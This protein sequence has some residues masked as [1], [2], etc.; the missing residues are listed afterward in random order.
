MGLCT[1]KGAFCGAEVLSQ[2]SV[3][4]NKWE[5]ALSAFGFLRSLTGIKPVSSLEFHLAHHAWRG[6]DAHEM[7]QREWGFMTW[8]VGSL[9][10]ERWWICEHLLRVHYTVQIDAYCCS[11]S[12]ARKLGTLGTLTKSCPSLLGYTPAKTAQN[13]RRTCLR[14]LL[15]RVESGRQLPCC[16]WPRR[17]LWAVALECPSEHVPSVLEPF[18]SVGPSCTHSL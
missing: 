5:V 2:S 4:R 1:G 18:R 15:H 13:L 10:R 12:D 14:R 11:S 7:S 9:G 16:L 17:L 3:F 6:V 8:A